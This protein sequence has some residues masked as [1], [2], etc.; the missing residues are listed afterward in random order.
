MYQSPS[1]MFNYEGPNAGENRLRNFQSRNR[2]YLN[3]NISTKPNSTFN[4]KDYSLLRRGRKSFVTEVR[5]PVELV[6][7]QFEDK[8]SKID[9]SVFERVN[10]QI[11]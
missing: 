1:K 10:K 11:E 2:N 5:N 6:N 4:S 3:S 7:F 8:D 9:L